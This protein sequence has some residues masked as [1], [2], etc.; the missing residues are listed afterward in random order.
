[1]KIYQAN[2]HKVYDYTRLSFTPDIYVLYFTLLT[3][4]LQYHSINIT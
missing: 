3:S 2:L 4:C 1:M